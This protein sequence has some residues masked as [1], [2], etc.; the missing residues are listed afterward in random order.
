MLVS[1]V[2]TD[3]LLN[4]TR[5][6]IVF[7]FWEG[8]GGGNKLVFP[9]WQYTTALSSVHQHIANSWWSCQR[10]SAHCHSIHPCVCCVPLSLSGSGLTGS[11]TSHCASSLGS[12]PMFSLFI[13][14]SRALWSCIRLYDSYLTQTQYPTSYIN[15]LFSLFDDVCNLCCQPM[16]PVV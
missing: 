3:K 13:S 9:W 4:I 5:F 16:M 7:Q 6:S 14:L 10:Y 1:A 2:C 8:W 11:G 15:K 12:S